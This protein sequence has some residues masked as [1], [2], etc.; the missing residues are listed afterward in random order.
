L[1][2]LVSP[3]RGVSPPPRL[4]VSV[5]PCLPLSPS[6]FGGFAEEQRE[7]FANSG[8]EAFMAPFQVV[9]NFDT[10][11]QTAALGTKVGDALG[12]RVSKT[13]QTLALLTLIDQ[14]LPSCSKPGLQRL[15]GLR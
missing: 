9:E 10:A 14:A 8:A 5:S 13:P 2:V 11:G 12:S 7:N 15:V 1:R 6:I 4:R 3:T